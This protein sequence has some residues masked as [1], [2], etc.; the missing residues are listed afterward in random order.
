[1]LFF[2][3]CLRKMLFFGI[4]SWSEHCEDKRVWQEMEERI[5][6][7]LH[8]YRWVEINRKDHEIEF[9]N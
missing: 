2:I 3:V 1:M 9:K 5:V 4:L 8:G 6:I 7:K